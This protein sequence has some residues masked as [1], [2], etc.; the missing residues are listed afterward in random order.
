MVNSIE[1][2]KFFAF[3]LINLSNLSILKSIGEGTHLVCQE[4]KN[5]EFPLII[6]NT[7]LF[8]RKDA[9][10]VFKVMKNAS[11]LQTAWSGLN[12][13]N[14]NINSVGVNSLNKFLPLSS[15]DFNNFFGLYCVNVPV[16]S[17]A[18][19]KQLTEL[20]LLNIFS[21][22]FFGKKVFVDQNTKPLNLDVFGKGKDTL[23][24][25]YF[26]LPSNLFLEDSETFINTQGLVKRTTKLLSFKKDA[27]SNWQII[28]KFY[29]KS[30]SLFFFNQ[31]K[32]QHF[33]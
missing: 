19:M 24:D 18:A 26:H 17:V 10:L 31:K 4:F 5:S 23:Y 11:A 7:E 12:I 25:Q 27:K 8:K 29:A 32:R 16:S 22:N 2:F 6:T 21:T 33:D 9:K 14:H 28:R 15:E 13:L 1:K 30:K 3:Q 20:H